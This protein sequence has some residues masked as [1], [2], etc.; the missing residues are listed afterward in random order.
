ML[1][2]RCQ[3]RSDPVMSHF[4]LPIAMGRIAHFMS[5]YCRSA[6]DWYERSAPS[7]AIV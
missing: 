4:F 1:T 5:D 2:A 3:A 7:W 6:D